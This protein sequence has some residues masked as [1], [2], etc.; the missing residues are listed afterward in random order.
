M[1]K[2]GFSG[3]CYYQ[4]KNI[5]SG[6][7]I[8]ELSFYHLGKTKFCHQISENKCKHILNRECERIEKELQELEREM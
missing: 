8:C 3:Y 5:S 1:S 2:T 4:N 6:L 7:N